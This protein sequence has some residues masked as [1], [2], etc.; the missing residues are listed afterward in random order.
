ME[1]EVV[2]RKKAMDEYKTVDFSGPVGVSKKDAKK[3]QDM[4]QKMR[5]EQESEEH[6]DKNNE[7]PTVDEPTVNPQS[8]SQKNNKPA[9][10]ESKQPKAPQQ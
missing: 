4:L 6:P 2:Q 5:E 1:N 10:S 3:L 7:T 8:D 9:N